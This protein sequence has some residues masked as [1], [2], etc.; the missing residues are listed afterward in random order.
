VVGDADVSRLARAFPEPPGTPENRHLVRWRLQRAG[1]A[2]AIAAW[3]EDVPIGYCVVRWP[4][5]GGE[6]TAQ[7]KALQCAE[8]GDLFV[9]A[10]WRRRGIARHLV[11]AAETAAIDHGCTRLGLEVTVANPDNEDARQLYADLGFVDAGVGEFVS[12]YRYW[13]PDGLALRDEELHRYLIKE[14]AAG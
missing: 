12:G 14:L 3:R 8:L 5:A 11:E 9:A 1:L 2:T 7:A 4:V 10:E 13:T 6:A